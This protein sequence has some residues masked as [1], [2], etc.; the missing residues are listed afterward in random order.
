VFD[1][2][3]SR[4]AAIS[5]DWL[6]VM[7]YICGIKLFYGV[8]LRIKDRITQVLVTTVDNTVIR[9]ND[10]QYV[11]FHA[12]LGKVKADGTRLISYYYFYRIGGR[13]GKQ[14][15]YFIGN[16][17]QIDAGVARRI[18]AKIE[19]R[20][21]QGEDILRLKFD[22]EKEHV[23]LNDF[24][25]FSGEHFFKNKYKNSRDAIRCIEQH[26]LAQLGSVP[27]DKLTHHLVM[28]RIFEPLLKQKKHSQLK[29]VASQLRALLQHAVDNNYLVVQPI[30]PL[31]GIIKS[32]SV[33]SKSPLLLTG[34]QIKGIYYR[35]MKTPNRLAYLYTLRIQILTGQSLSTILASYR[36][37]IKGNY[38]SLRATNGKL[39]GK[40][41]P[42]QGP[43]KTLFKE[44]IAG[45]SNPTSLFLFPS[46]LSRN[47]SDVAMDP[48]AIAKSQQRFIL[49]VQ[50]TKVTSSELV[51]NIEL[52]MVDLG[53]PGLVV[54]HLFNRKIETY[55]RLDPKD[56]SISAGL[57]QWYS[58]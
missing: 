38:W 44:A 58:G 49:A 10:S 55:L 45:F 25:R 12:R 31:T 23:R 54:A 16:S 22:A 33:A 24:W 47:G 26:V 35:A 7:C 52:A 57:T 46:K 13:N 19:P 11:G 3:W 42:V 18:A 5:I 34:P 8:I 39:T 14:C 36:Q 41:I 50:G 21:K 29:V 9:I 43:L 15:N 28:L 20:I 17:E 30:K 4:E 40:K 56:Q 51:K 48:R 37:D 32:K 1:L 27:L 2:Q 53:V 6:D